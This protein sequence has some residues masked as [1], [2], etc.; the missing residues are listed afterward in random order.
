M[1][2]S[3]NQ[4]PARARS[5]ASAGTGGRQTLR[6]QE[7]GAGEPARATSFPCSVACLCGGRASASPFFLFSFSKFLCVLSLRFLFFLFLFCQPAEQARQGRG[8]GECACVEPTA[9]A[10]ESVTPCFPLRSP[11]RARE[12]STPVRL[13]P[14]SA[15]LR[16]EQG[17]GGGERRAHR[18][19][20]AVALASLPTPLVP[21]PRMRSA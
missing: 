12:Q 16:G 2:R 3:G 11:V 18:Q 19:K 21:A 8:Q 13:R 10:L 20:E 17:E 7:R 5:L 4:P 15:A 1:R 9:R 14:L 6:A